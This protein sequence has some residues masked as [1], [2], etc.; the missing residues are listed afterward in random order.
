MSRA[1]ARLESAVLFLCLVV[2]SGCAPHSR[3]T[4]EPQAASVPEL[5]S[6]PI[7]GQAVPKAAPA[8]TESAD[9]AT[10]RRAAWLRKAGLG[11]HAES[12]QDWDGIAEEAKREG[13]V[14]VYSS[15]SRLKYAAEG[16]MAMYPEI[17]VE[18]LDM[19][20]KDAI[21][22]LRHEQATG[23]HRCDVYFAGNA[24]VLSQ[25]LL[26]TGMA[27]TF[28]PTELTE[29]LPQEHRSP[30]VQ[31]LSVDVLIYN[32]DAYDAP[33]IDSWWD[34]TRPAWMGRIVL[35]DPTNQTDG[36]HL[37]VAMVQHPEDMARAYE[38]EFGE[39]KRLDE[40]CENAGYQWIKD[41]L[42]ARPVFVAGGIEVAEAVGAPDQFDPPVGICP[43]AQY[44]K[45]I[46][47]SLY[48]EPVFDLSPFSSVPVPTC[49]AIA[50]S[51]PHPDAAKLMIRWLMGDPSQD[52]MAGFSPWWV[53][54]EYSPRS[55]I[56]AP[57]HA[58]PWHEVASSAWSVDYRFAYQETERVREFWLAHAP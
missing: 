9:S 16:F 6:T 34:L 20:T 47:H 43:Y 41:F 56:P 10:E 26:A 50:D 14:T 38:V 22:T 1:R 40:E 55:D 30:L 25:E 17:Q 5:A 29:V 27:W 36:V 49:L 24:P 53:L 46:R 12:P 28:I 58:R 2:L 13:K 37:F 18:A 11:A 48:F 45:A 4:I 15:S 57:A 52:Q 44:S 21:L 31:R 39:S 33:P 19:G 3:S 8:A 23:E 32:T 7:A 54:G 42:E 35:R 51:A